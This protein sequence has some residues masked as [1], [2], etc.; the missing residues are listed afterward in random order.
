MTEPTAIDVR[1]L[2]CSDA[3]VRLHKAIV[4]VPP[5]ARVKVVAD[6]REVVADLE[7]YAARGGHTWEGALVLDGG[8]IKAGVRKGA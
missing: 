8:L 4:A 5:G 7:R 2:T 3:V 1:G 6:D